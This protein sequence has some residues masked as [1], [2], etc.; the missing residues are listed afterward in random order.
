MYDISS[1]LLATSVC[2]LLLTPWLSEP[3]IRAC[4]NQVVAPS[5][6]NTENIVQPVQ[7]KTRCRGLRVML[8][9]LSLLST[10]M[11][12][13]WAIMASQSVPA[14]YQYCMATAVIGSILGATLGTNLLYLWINSCL[15]RK[16]AYAPTKG[17]AATCHCLVHY[18]AIQ[19]VRDMKVVNEIKEQF[20][21]ADV[22]PSSLECSERE[23]CSV[24]S[25]ISANSRN[26]SASNEA[27]RKM[28]QVDKTVDEDQQHQGMVELID[29]ADES[30][31][32]QIENKV[33]D[34]LHQS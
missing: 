10:V 21:L 34:V 1:L 32:M 33:N 13:V 6:P 15:A 9:T 19:I 31:K 5:S 16:A 17:K 29:E 25:G 7:I 18:K 14:S 22:L 3:L 8:I 11:L 20:T 23:V 12:P 2:T 24:H 28:V 4:S 30:H 26:I 27:G